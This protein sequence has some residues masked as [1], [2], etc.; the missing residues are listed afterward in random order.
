MN[1]QDECLCQALMNDLQLEKE[2]RFIRNGERYN[3]TEAANHLRRKFD[4]AKDRLNSVTDFIDKL[5]SASWF[6]GEPYMVV[7]PGGRQLKARDYLIS[8]LEV[9][10]EKCP[11]GGTEQSRN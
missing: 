3:S 10:K 4:Y 5:A 7:L 1:A 9:V 8:R 11:A 6:S 2:L